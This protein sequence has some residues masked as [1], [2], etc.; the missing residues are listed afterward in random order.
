MHTS[1]KDSLTSLQH[2][3]AAM[4]AD[5]VTKE[6]FATLETR[7]AALETKASTGGSNIDAAWMQGQ[8]SRLD[9][10]NKTLFV[11]GLKQDN[12]TTRQTILEEYIAGAG[13]KEDIVSI[14]HVWS[15]PAGQRKISPNALVEFRSRFVREACLIKLNA[16]NSNLKTDGILTCNRAKT[17]VQLKRNGSLIRALELFKKDARCKDKKIDIC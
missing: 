5:M 2:D 4:K 9:P 15:G 10:A 1:L 13:F 12:P 8:M 17:A 16:T 3:I 6:L 14:E 7:V 11:K